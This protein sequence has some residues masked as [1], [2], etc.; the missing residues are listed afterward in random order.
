MKKVSKDEMSKKKLMVKKKP[1]G[2][3]ATKSP[4]LQQNPLP[5]MIRD[6]FPIYEEVKI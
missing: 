3:P 5:A 4:E 2:P 1:G 6:L